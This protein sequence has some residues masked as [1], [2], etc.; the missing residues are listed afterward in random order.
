MRSEAVR[1]AQK[2]YA[3]KKQ[4]V[5]SICLQRDTD[6]GII[7]LLEMQENRNGFLRKLL[8]NYLDKNN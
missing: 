4:K 1:R 5:F 6:A 2:K 7:E 3:L 8:R